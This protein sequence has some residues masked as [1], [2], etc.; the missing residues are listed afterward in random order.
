MRKTDNDLKVHVFVCTNLKVNKECC[1]ARGA[2][3]FRT[4]LKEWAKS[5]PLWRGQL[6]INASGC[7]DHCKEGIAVAI[8]PKGGLLLNVS[9]PDLAEVKKIIENLLEEQGISPP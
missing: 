1:A 5:H 7:L 9:P 8:Y 2:E 4:Q 6:R 3:D